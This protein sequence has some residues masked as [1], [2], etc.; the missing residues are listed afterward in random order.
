M[1]VINDP[2]GQ[3]VGPFLARNRAIMCQHVGFRL[4]CW[5]FSPGITGNLIYLYIGAILVRVCV[6]SFFCTGIWN[7][8]VCNT[9]GRWR[10]MSQSDFRRKCPIIY[11][12][13]RCY[14][15]IW[16]GVEWQLDI[17]GEIG[18]L[19][20]V[21]F[22]IWMLVVL[23]YPVYIFSM[24]SDS[25][26]AWKKRI[27][28]NDRKIRAPIANLIANLKC[29]LHIVS[30]TACIIL[31]FGM[32]SGRYIGEGVLWNAYRFLLLCGIAK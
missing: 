1:C 15:Y 9:V 24:I 21:F 16:C 8:G 27:F 5:Q 14:V 32:V 25:I 3:I 10:L 19:K 30:I 13:I 4:F 2:C 6:C 26:L 31:L 29:I 28:F 22:L 11:R 20:H 17:I 23:L 7:T 12:K 18:Y